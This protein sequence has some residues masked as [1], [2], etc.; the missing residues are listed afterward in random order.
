MMI[1]GVGNELLRTEEVEECDTFS[2]TELG[3]P[4]LKDKIWQLDQQE[5]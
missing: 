1:N 2:V 4:F 3:M 5:F